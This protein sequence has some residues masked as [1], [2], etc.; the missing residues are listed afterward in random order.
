MKASSVFRHVSCNPPPPPKCRTLYHHNLVFAIVLRIS[1]LI[2]RRGSG[3]GNEIDCPPHIVV[4]FST[5]VRTCR[6][7]RCQK[8]AIRVW[9]TQFLF[10]KTHLSKNEKNTSPCG[11]ARRLPGT[12][13]SRR[14]ASKTG[15]RAGHFFF[16]GNV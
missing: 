14:I 12:R 1:I 4:S 5:T 8:T 15:F 2:F 7:N 9:R 3:D 10:R 6:R 11:R 16:S 13:F